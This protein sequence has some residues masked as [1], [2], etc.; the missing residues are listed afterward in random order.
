MEC[1]K[2]ETSTMFLVELPMNLHLSPFSNSSDDVHNSTLIIQQNNTQKV[3]TV[4]GLNRQF[5][6]IKEKTL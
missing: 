3:K 5:M 6:L 1:L 2:A 4:K